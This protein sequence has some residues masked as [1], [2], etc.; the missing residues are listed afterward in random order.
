MKIEII[1]PNHCIH[2]KV[3]PLKVEYY[4]RQME[5]GEF[6]PAIEVLLYKNQYFVKN[7]AHRVCAAKILGSEILAEVY[8]IES[9]KDLLEDYPNVWL[10]GSRL[11][12]KK[13]S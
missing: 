8:R 11:N 6:F 12:W 1:D 7:G 5:N 2:H 13:S 4:K 10:L 3:N 9:K